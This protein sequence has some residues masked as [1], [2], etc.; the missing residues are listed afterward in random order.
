MEENLSLAVA[1]AIELGIS[2]EAIQKSMQFIRPPMHRLELSKRGTA[3]VVDNTYSSNSAGLKQI[4]EDFGAISG[5]KA[6]ITPGIVELGSAEQEIHETLGVEMAQVFNSVILVGETARTRGLRK[7][8][9][10]G[11][12]TGLLETI[13]ADTKLYWQKVEELSKKYQWILLENDVSEQYL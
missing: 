5:L 6:I 11:G 13:P 9:K 1:V 12:F 4:I 3:T 2:D 8:L 10:T 7:G